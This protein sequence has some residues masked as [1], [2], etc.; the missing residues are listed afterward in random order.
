MLCF[1]AYITRSKKSIYWDLRFRDLETG[2]WRSRSTRCRAD[3]PKQTRA[4]QRMAEDASA[5]EGKVGP[6]ADGEFAAW[7]LDYIRRHYD[8]AASQ[9]RY[10]AAWMR[11]LEWARLR[12]IRHPGHVRYE[13]AS[14]FM[15]WRVKGGASHNTARLELKFLSFVLQEAMRRDLIQK[16]PIALAKVP[17][18]P[19]KL[20]QDLDS[21]DFQK[22]RAAF[23]ERNTSPWMLTVFEICAHLGCRFREAELGRDDVDFE[24]GVIWLTD[25]KRKAGDPR[26]RFSVPIPPS[27]DKHLR[28]VFLTRERTAPDLSWGEHN[29]RFN[30]TLKAATGATSHSLRVA[31]VTRCH[32]AGLNESQAM[33]LVNHSTRLVHAVY[34][35][36][37]VNDAR[38]A[39]AR[40][41]PPI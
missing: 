23:S 30:V 17:R 35:R 19:A 16:N 20:K 15:D 36:L 6:D 8:R 4:A 38:E 12:G 33:R 13:H 37:S 39:A 22:A 40:V 18:V 5:L 1:M 14:D 7:A 34:S 26:K 29:T 41:M 2:R 11:I 32:R 9:K 31:F 21:A 28:G 24:T 27:L 3:D 10:E 25:S